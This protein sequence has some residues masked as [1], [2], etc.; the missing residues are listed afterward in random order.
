MTLTLQSLARNPFDRLGASRFDSSVL[1]GLTLQ[2]YL[3]NPPQMPPAAAPVGHEPSSPR[4]EP[5]DVRSQPMA[6]KPTS[7]GDLASLPNAQ[8]PKGN[9]TVKTLGDIAGIL[10][11]AFM[12]YGGLRPEFAPALAQQQ[13]DERRNDF[14]RERLN[15]ELEA[16]REAALA[17]RM[18]QVGNTIGLLDPRAQSFTPTYTAPAAPEQYAAALGYE[19]GTPDYH[20]A[21]R[22][23]RLGA[24]SD[25]AVEA[26][27]GLLDHRF[28]RSDAQLGQRLATTQRGQD[29]MHG[30]RQAAIGQS[31]TNNLRSTNTSREN[32]I[33]STDT[34]RRNNVQNSFTRLTTARKVS[35]QPM[36]VNSPEEARALP[37]G[38]QFMTPDGRVKIR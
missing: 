16:K 20:Q 13:Q 15:L 7:L 21:V 6:A 11:D 18:E 35:G 4:F 33:R 36:L 34:S 32:N 2:Q 9:K 30:D 12:A 17:P 23:Y 19:P 10:G 22:D 28:D 24:W 38:T 5:V 14:D 29:L 3:R 26:K 8:V 37:K 31:N 27:T 1:P 25:P